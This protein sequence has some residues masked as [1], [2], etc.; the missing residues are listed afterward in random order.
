MNYFLLQ[1]DVFCKDEI[2]DDTF[3]LVDVAYLSGWKR[4]SVYI[5]PVVQ[6]NNGV[7]GYYNT[8]I[9]C[10]LPVRLEKSKCIYYACGPIK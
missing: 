2:L 3:T 10:S 9:D 8:Y 5:I 6:L 4:V 1:I 7:K